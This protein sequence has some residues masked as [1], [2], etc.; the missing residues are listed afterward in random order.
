[1]WHE[2]SALSYKDKNYER[3]KTYLNKAKNISYEIGNFFFVDRCNIDLALTM[4]KLSQ[5]YFESISL[6]KNIVNR[7]IKINDKNKQKLESCLVNEAYDLLI[8]L[9]KNL[10]PDVIMLNSNPIRNYCSALHSGIFAYMNNQYYILKNLFEKIK[11]NIKI[12]SIVLNKDNLIKSFDNEGKILI[13]QSDDFTE[14]G[15][16]ILESDTGESIFLPIEEFSKMIPI[17]IKYK[18]VILCFV[19]SSKLVKLFDDKVEYLITFD[20]INLY[21]LD[22][23]T[24]FK[25]NE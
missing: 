9:K 13:I 12:K 15:E 6:L 16:L 18:I 25:Y 14:N 11:L 22:Y 19:N 7:K 5:G 20:E 17:K 3:A 21:D 1:M 10:E 4:K 24:L 2:I 8:E 23:N